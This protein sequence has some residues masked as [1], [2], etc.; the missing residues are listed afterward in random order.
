MPNRVSKR[1]LK[2]V[3]AA[4]DFRE[5]GLTWNEYRKLRSL[6]TPHKIQAY[7]DA[8]PSNFEI[9]GETVLPVREVMRQQRAHCIEGGFLAACAFWINGERPLLMHLKA[10][11]DFHHVIT[12]FQRGGYW[13]A[14]SK[15]NAVYLRYRDPIYRTLRELALSFMH[16]YANKSG[17]KTLRAFSDPFDLS[18]VE[19]S[20]W[21]C[22]DDNCWKIHDRL[23]YLPHTRLVTIGQARALR[24]FESF[25]RSIGKTTQHKRPAKA[26]LSRKA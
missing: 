21:V 24:R 9:G 14:V 11:N 22:N 7:L 23:Y 16:E 18:R 3:V 10:V 20:M 4:P 17:K 25:Q 6:D 8:M 26:E 19:P 5:L 15:T 2:S 12:L 1:S 13:G